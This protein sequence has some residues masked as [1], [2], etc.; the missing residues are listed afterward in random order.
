M[1]R[2]ALLGFPVHHSISP[3]IYNAAFEALHIDARYEAI[4]VR[5]EALAS[6]VRDLRNAGFRGWNVTLPHKERI[7]QYIEVVDPPA[8]EV[9]AVNTVYRAGPALHGANTDVAGIVES[10]EPYRDRIAGK[11]ALIF[12]AGG[13]ARAAVVALTG[14]LGC[15]RLFLYNRTRSRAE[16]LLRDFGTRLREKRVDIAIV[17]EAGLDEALRR[18]VC[19]VNTT[20]AG[21]HPYEDALP[22]PS[23]RFRDSHVAF[24][25][26]YVPERTRFLREAEAAGAR[27]VA[28]LDMLIRQAACAFSLW[29]GRSMPFDAAR[30]AATLELLQ[31]SR[32]S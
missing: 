3:A 12:G 1:D 10:L 31:R 11:S 14:S 15:I 23:I 27:C 19:V 28:G 5:P 17:D 7:L 32:L 29:T 21:M 24:D 2:Y 20:S 26:V 25:A 6:T 22:A 8:A 16:L 9:G 30:N 13:A 18:A 4:E